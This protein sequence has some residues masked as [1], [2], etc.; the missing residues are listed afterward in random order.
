MNDFSIIIDGHIVKELRCKNDD[1]RHLLGYDNII[2]GV[3]IAICPKCGTQNIY[4]I[5]YRQ[6]G[7]ELAKKLK[8]L[9]LREGVSKQ[10]G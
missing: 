3:F 9:E 10:N 4:K 1:C 2:L 6:Q 5:Q 7:K 8:E